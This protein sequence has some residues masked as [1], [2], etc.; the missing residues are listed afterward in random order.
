MQDAG[1][2]ARLDHGRRVG[3][4]ALVEQTRRRT[5][6]DREVELAVAVDVAQLERPHRAVGV[7]GDEHEVEDADQPAVDEVDEDREPFA[8]HLVA[9]ELDDQVADR[10]QRVRFVCHHAIT[11]RVAHRMG[12]STL[13][14]TKTNRA[15]IGGDYRTNG[16]S[17]H[18]RRVCR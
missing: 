9:G 18:S 13:R 16:T 11:F 10:S 12:I 7:A 4:V 5:L 2:R 14:S 8:G 15:S 17:Q 3:E 1:R 6:E